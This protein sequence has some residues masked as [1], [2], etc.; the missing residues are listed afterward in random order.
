MLIAKSMIRRRN[1]VRLTTDD[2]FNVLLTRKSN[3]ITRRWRRWM[4]DRRQ[5]SVVS[6][7]SF[8]NFVTNQLLLVYC[9]EFL[10]GTQKHFSIVAN[11]SIGRVD[12]D[13]L[14]IYKNG[15][16]ISRSLVV[17]DEIR[18]LAKWRRPKNWSRSFEGSYLR[19]RGAERWRTLET[20]LD[21]FVGTWINFWWT[22][23]LGVF[24]KRFSSFYRLCSSS[25]LPF[26][27]SFKA[28]RASIR[29]RRLS[30]S[31]FF[32]SIYRL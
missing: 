31:F 29:G 22:G 4:I 3:N 13:F 19:R 2:L 16:V 26:N 28:C 9:I 5:S 10:A 21:S 20:I 17:A 32:F 11:S 23:F 25:S 14:A 7:G 6:L 24:S 15:N 1:I 12:G 18:S 8:L 27:S 30:S